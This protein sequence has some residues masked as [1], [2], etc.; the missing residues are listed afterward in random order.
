MLFGKKRKQKQEEL[1]AKFNKVAKDIQAIDDWDDPQKIQHYI[2]DSCEQIISLTKEIESEKAEYRILTSYLSDIQ[3][4]SQLPEDKAKDLRTVAEQIVQLSAARKAYQE[5]ERRISDTDYIRMEEN[6]ENIPSTI[7]R[8][9][10]NE[11]Y[12]AQI[13]KNMNMLEGQKG[14]HDVELDEIRRSNKFLRRIS[15]LGL[16]AIVSLGVFLF[17][18][19]AEVEVDITPYL[20]G[21]LFLAACFGMFLTMRSSKLTKRRREVNHHRNQTISLLNVVRMKYANVTRAIEYEQEHYRVKSSYE[22]NYM[23]EAYLE[24]FRRKEQYLRDNDDLEYFTGRLMR[25]L[26]GMDL[27]DRKIWL[28]QTKAL[29]K[30]EDMQSVSHD[31]IERRKK[32]RSRI[33]ENTRSVKSERDEVDRLMREHNYY[34]PEILEIITSVD[35]LC[36]LR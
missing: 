24:A 4:I 8:M 22:L 18:I 35:R 23:W 14:E 11:R 10:E 33:S 20:L 19:G 28:S 9:Q 6:E 21:L 31:L 25:I 17:M 12:Q 34:V 13:K 30:Q 2:L 27:Y 36:G 26:G 32:I 29:I 1:D 5:G 7:Y 3:K 15:V 16:I